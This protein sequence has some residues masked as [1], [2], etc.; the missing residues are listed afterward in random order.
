MDIKYK[1][2]DDFFYKMLGRPEVI[3]TE[4]DSTLQDTRSKGLENN[5]E[6]EI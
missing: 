1:D 3:Y 4:S 2:I 6:H 5:A